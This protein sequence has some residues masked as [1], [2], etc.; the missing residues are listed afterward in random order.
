MSRSRKKTAVRTVCSA[1]AGQM[2]R[3]KENCNK[4]VRRRP[5]EE[6]IGNNTTYKRMNDVWTSPSDG[7]I[8]VNQDKDYEKWLRK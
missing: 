5:V 7:K 8:W 6:D 2:K 3:W 4:R 1:R